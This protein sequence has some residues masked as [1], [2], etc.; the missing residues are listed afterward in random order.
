[1]K[2]YLKDTSDKWAPA[3]LRNFKCRRRDLESVKPGRESIGGASI[4]LTALSNKLSTCPRSSPSNEG[5]KLVL[6]AITE[7]QELPCND[8]CLS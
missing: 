1:M 7:F 5:Q 4:S 8:R 6:R 2:Q 3:K